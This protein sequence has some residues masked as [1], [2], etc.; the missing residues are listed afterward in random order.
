MNKHIDEPKEEYIPASWYNDFISS[1]LSIA[2]MI[3]DL[4]IHEDASRVAHWHKKL[5]RTVAKL[6]SPVANK[7]LF[8][9]ETSG[10]TYGRELAVQ[11]TKHQM[12]TA[13]VKEFA[14]MAANAMV[15]V[16]DIGGK[17]CLDSTRET[18][19]NTAHANMLASPKLFLSGMIDIATT[20]NENEDLAYDSYFDGNIKRATKTYREMDAADILKTTAQKYK[21]DHSSRKYTETNCSTGRANPDMTRSKTA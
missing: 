10:L 3:Q 8:K 19:S 21:A 18:I 2:S 14:M 7:E 1:E 20:V 13:I 17:R 16:F 4:F 5:N 11:Q 9:S 6:M 12:R 15:R